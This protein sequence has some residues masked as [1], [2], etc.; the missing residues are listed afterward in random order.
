MFAIGGGGEADGGAELAGESGLIAVS[1]FEGDF[2]DGA[3]G[4]G[5]ELGGVFDAGF[6]DEL[7]G[8]ELEDAAHAAVELGGG[9]AC[10]GGEVVGFQVVIEV[11]LDVGDDALDAGEFDIFLAGCAEVAGDGGDADDVSCGIV[12]GDFGGEVPAERAIAVGDEFEAVGEFA[13]GFE[14]GDVLVAVGF[15]E[16]GGEEILG[17]FS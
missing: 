2:R 14:D 17:A 11:V 15:G 8:G 9:K 4:G 6:A 5:E 10:G 12:E 13:A 16:V 3:A 1:A 7:R